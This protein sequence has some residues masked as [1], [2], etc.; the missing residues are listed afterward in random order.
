MVPMD[1][2][3][4]GFPDWETFLRALRSRFG[5]SAN[6]DPLGKIAKLVQTGSVTNFREEFEQLMT[7]I[8]GVPEQ[9]FLNYFVWGV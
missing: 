3:G 6:E 2:E 5:T 1:G 9:Y 7:R 8:S 4:G